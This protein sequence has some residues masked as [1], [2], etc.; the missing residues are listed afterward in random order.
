MRAKSPF[1]R[2]IEHQIHPNEE[3]LIASSNLICLRCFV[4][5]PFD[6]LSSA[7]LSYSS[8]LPAQRRGPTEALVSP[9]QDLDRIGTIPQHSTYPLVHGFSHKS[10]FSLWHDCLSMHA[11]AI[12]LPAFKYIAHHTMG[13]CPHLMA[14]CDI[15]LVEVYRMT[16]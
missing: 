10:Y 12:L 5:T 8:Q 15:H 16:R 11:L 14:A 7:E 3:S 13:S 9:G 6:P 1:F 2:W 4:A